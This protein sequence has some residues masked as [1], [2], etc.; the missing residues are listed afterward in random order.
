MQLPDV[1]DQRLECPGCGQ[2]FAAPDIRGITIGVELR[3]GDG[4]AIV[5]RLDSL[6]RHRTD[7]IHECPTGGRGGDGALMP[8]WPPHAPPSRRT[9]IAIDYPS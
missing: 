5:M 6:L 2:V 1:P 8:A 3:E 4:I 7:V 9:S